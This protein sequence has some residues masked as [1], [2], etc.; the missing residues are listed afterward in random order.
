MNDLDRR[1]FELYL[2]FE[3]PEAGKWNRSPR[4]LYIE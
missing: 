2:S 1:L 3:G 4:S